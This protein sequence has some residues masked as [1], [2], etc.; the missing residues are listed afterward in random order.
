MQGGMLVTPNSRSVAVHSHQ[1]RVEVAVASDLRAHRRSRCSQGRPC[2]VGVCPS[3]WIPPPGTSGDS[4]STLPSPGAG[5]RSWAAPASSRTSRKGAHTGSDEAS[6]MW[7]V[8]VE[9]RR[10]R[11]RQR[12]KINTSTAFL[13]VLIS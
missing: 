2:G 13:S 6:F 10:K 11:G 12:E 3:V 7:D 4:T 1:G 9:E 5:R 8:V